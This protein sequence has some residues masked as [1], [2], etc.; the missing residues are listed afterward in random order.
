MEINKISYDHL[1]LLFIEFITVRVF[2]GV[3]CS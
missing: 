2:S 1:G 3:L